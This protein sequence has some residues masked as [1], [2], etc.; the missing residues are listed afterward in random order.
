M[1]TIV[2]TT[3][4]GRFECEKGTIL[5]AVL[6]TAGI[7][8]PTDC[9]GHGVCGKCRVDIF[10]AR[11]KETVLACRYA[12]TEDIVIE[13]PENTE[14]ALQ[15]ANM[16]NDLP[17]CGGACV[18][19]LGTTS[20]S[21]MIS[22]NGKNFEKTE[23][24]CL[25][26]YGSDVISR[27]SYI[28][29]HDALEKLSGEI[30]DQIYKMVSGLCSS[31]GT[32]MPDIMY[33]AGNTVMQHILA[34]IDPFPITVYPFSPKT[35]FRGTKAYT[36]MHG[37]RSRLMPCIAGYFGGDL[38]AGLYWLK[39]KLKD[40]GKY[41]FVDIGT[42]GEM[43]LIDG[44]SVTCCSV[45]SGPAFE[46]GNIECGMPGINGAIEK[47]SVRNSKLVLSVIGNGAAQGI[48]GSGLIDLT[49][50]LLN[51]G[52]IHM[53]GRMLPPSE[54]E[55]ELDGYTED[56]DENGYILL[57]DGVHLSAKDVRM[58]QMAK[59]AVAAGIETLMCEANVRPDDID[60][61]FLAGGFGTLL[62]I[63]SAVR[64]GMIPRELKDRCIPVGNTSLKGAAKAMADGVSGHELE[65]ICLRCRYIEL[66]EL[67]QFNER[68]VENM[69]FG[70]N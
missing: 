3:K 26:V 35:L 62:D 48:C 38:V 30:K 17:F 21:V 10:S 2:V 64:I 36:D 56:D 39:D 32:D 63:D 68:Y 28:K 37:I 45:A 23:L 65:D 27:V 1:S 8:V 33:I 31:A 50:A 46:G 60:A 52:I 58:L 67:K 41:L 22:A 15:T 54:S 44:D 7:A 5:L 47:A 69:L 43:A 59:A 9:G 55:T 19:D 14:G 4:Y 66:S 11:G 12:V 16:I 61:L 13:L 34:G 29:E 6:R 40:N 49:A 20:V 25:S 51:E 42:N 18:C 53:S 24:N 70:G 57:A